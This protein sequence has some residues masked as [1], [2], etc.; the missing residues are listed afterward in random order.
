MLAP[1][2][3]ETGPKENVH[4]EGKFNTIEAGFEKIKIRN[5]N[6]ILL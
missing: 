6:N 4:E 2:D 3:Y 1:G 5:Y